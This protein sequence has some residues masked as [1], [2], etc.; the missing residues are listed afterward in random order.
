MS[1]PTLTG[2]C[3]HGARGDELADA[4]TPLRELPAQPEPTTPVPSSIDNSVSSASTGSRRGSG[5]KESL[6]RLMRGRSKSKVQP[7][8]SA[9]VSEG[10]MSVRQPILQGHTGWKVLLLRGTGEGSVAGL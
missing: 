7:V 3:I 6:R 1:S 8:G 5:L 10:C 2:F 4:E 9:R